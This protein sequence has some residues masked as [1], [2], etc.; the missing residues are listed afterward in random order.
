M[1]RVWN[2]I[3][4]MKKFNIDNFFIIIIIS[5][6]NNLNNEKYKISLNILGKEMFKS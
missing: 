5:L 3:Y 2:T 4:N 6:N 1:I